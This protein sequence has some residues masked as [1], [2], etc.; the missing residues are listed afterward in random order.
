[1]H[2]LVLS[3]LPSTSASSSRLALISYSH[4]SWPRRLS[5]PSSFAPSSSPFAVSSPM[6]STR[7]GPTTLTLPTRHS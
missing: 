7:D 5:A 3:I 4:L 2:S 6:P 1:M